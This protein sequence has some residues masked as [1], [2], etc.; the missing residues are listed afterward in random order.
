LGYRVRIEDPRTVMSRL[1]RWR[2]GA[3]AF[4][5]LFVFSAGSCAAAGRRQPTASA[6]VNANLDCK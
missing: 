4:A 2:R 1:L 5:A 6:Y 3:R